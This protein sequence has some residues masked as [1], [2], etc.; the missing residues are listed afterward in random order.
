MRP[1][2]SVFLALSLDGFIAGENDDL[3]WL[4]PFSSD[5]PDDTGYTALINDIDV[6]VMGRNTYDTVINFDPWPYAGKRMV[7]M[8]RRELASRH[9]EEPFDGAL[10][11]LLDRLAAQ[12]HRHVY[13]DGGLTAREGIKA[14]VVDRITLSWVPIVLG[15]GIPL[16]GA[17]LPQTLLR[18]DDTKRLPS[19]LM[20]ATY[21]PVM[22]D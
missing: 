22:R 13:L 8:T 10:A 7:V 2:V 4:E 21:V 20:Q 16:F 19:G 15:K 11:T 12:G 1:R 9:G 14:G 18:L 3:S 6:I 5:S 17:E